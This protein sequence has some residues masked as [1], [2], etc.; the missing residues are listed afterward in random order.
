M[1][2]TQIEYGEVEKKI[3]EELLNICNHFGSRLTFGC[4]GFAGGVSDF[5]TLEKMVKTAK[6]VGV[7]T[8]FQ[9]SRDSIGLRGMLSILTSSLSMTRTAMSSVLPIPT[10]WYIVEGE[11]DDQILLK[12][13]INLLLLIDLSGNTSI[14]DV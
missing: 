7:K 2:P 3:D 9:N 13:K 12:T 8:W 6:S 11:Y 4:F 5:R 1:K 14:K 10:V